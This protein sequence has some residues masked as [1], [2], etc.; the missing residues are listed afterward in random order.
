MVLTFYEKLSALL[1]KLWLCFH[2]KLANSIYRKKYSMQLLLKKKRRRYF[3]FQ[4]CPLESL[5]T[6]DELVETLFTVV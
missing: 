1:L 5:I 6:S 2:C 4:M 3:M